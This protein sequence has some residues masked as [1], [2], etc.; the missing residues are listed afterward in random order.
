MKRWNFLILLVALLMALPVAA[1]EAVETE[2]AN[3]AWPCAEGEV[4]FQGIEYFAQ[5]DGEAIRTPWQICGGLN[6]YGPRSD[7]REFVFNDGAS[8]SLIRGSGEVT[9]ADGAVIRTLQFDFES[10]SYVEHDAETGELLLRYNVYMRET[11]LPVPTELTDDMQFELTL[12]GLDSAARY[13]RG[14]IEPDADFEQFG[15]EIAL[16]VYEEGRT[17]SGDIKATDPA[18]GDPVPFTLTYNR[19]WGGYVGYAGESAE[20]GCP[21]QL[22]FIG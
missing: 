6:T 2:V 5:D 1:Q 4:L 13:Y 12:C 9:N 15:G 17:L 14:L 16:D 3:P 18:A 22:A 19:M 7:S 21:M 20:S 8:R 11:Q 10:S